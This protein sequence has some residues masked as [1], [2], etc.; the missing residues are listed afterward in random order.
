MLIVAVAL[1]S[2][3]LG[4]G[5]FLAGVRRLG[6]S[7]ASIVSSAEPALTAAISFAVFGDRVRP[8]Q[9]LAIGL[10]FASVVILEVPGR[11]LRP[12][13]VTGYVAATRRRWSGG[14]DLPLYTR[15]R[16][17]MIRREALR[18]QA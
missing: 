3:V 2:T 6:P 17:P 16:W 8:L 5:A 12:G 7:R 1:G 9:L 10:V 4:I 14:V 13:R 18:P 11:F 15:S